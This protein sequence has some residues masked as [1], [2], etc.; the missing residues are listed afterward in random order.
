MQN[1]FSVLYTIYLTIFVGSEVLTRLLCTVYWVVIP[2]S[3][4]TPT[5]R[6]E[7]IA[8]I[9]RVEDKSSMR[10]AEICLPHI[11]DGFFFG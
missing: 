8:Y 7:R 11:S 4:D 6:E 9:F 1:L 10:Q 3:S 2:Y 5:F